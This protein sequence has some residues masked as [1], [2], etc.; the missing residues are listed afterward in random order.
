MTLK[1]NRYSACL[2]Y[3]GSANPYQ[4][5]LASSVRNHGYQTHNIPQGIKNLFQ[6]AISGTSDIV[7]FHWPDNYIFGNS[8]LKSYLKVFATLFCFSILKL[9]RKPIVWTLHN[10][11][12]HENRFADAERFFLFFFLRMANHVIAHCEFA[13]N[14]LAERHGKFL[15]G[16]TT[17]IPHGHYGGSYADPV[18]RTEARS[19]LGWAPADTTFLFVGNVRP[20]KGVLD[21]IDA[22]NKIER[23]AN[24]CIAGRTF[25]A[26]DEQLVEEAIGQNKSI[27]FIPGFI[28]E[29]DLALYLSASDV[30]VA[31]FKSVLT[32]GSVI[33]A[34]SFGLPCIAPKLGCLSEN[35]SFQPEL[36]YPPLD[37]SQLLNRLRFACDEPGVVVGV[38]QKNRQRSESEYS[39]DHVGQLTANVY[40]N[41]IG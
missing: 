26:D 40:G 39:W 33:L 8:L 1:G 24:L 2:P 10:L 37:T 38:G 28:E 32:S 31:P 27:R 3:N 18:T 19:I 41:L 17:V 15:L 36:L 13:R 11:N 25:S 34:M 6:I 16:K 20:Y 29:K 4:D 30:F 21:L 9:R 35:L 22:F 14:Q 5:L 23:D 12:N 7:H